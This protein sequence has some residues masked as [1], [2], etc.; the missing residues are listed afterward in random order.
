ME[1]WL[2]YGQDDKVCSFAALNALMEIENPEKTAICILSDKEEIGSMGNTG[3]ES[4]VF[5][6]FISEILN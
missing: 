5:D 2:G 1:W 6:T 4:H 3:M